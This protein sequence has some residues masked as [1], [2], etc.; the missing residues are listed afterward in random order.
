MYQ[1]I[2]LRFLLSIV[3]NTGG[4]PTR[5]PCIEV[6]LDW[7][8]SWK[9]WRVDWCC[10]IH[11][12]LQQKLGKLHSLMQPGNFTDYQLLFKTL[13]NTSSMHTSIEYIT[14]W[15]INVASFHTNI[16]LHFLGKF[17][18]AIELVIGAIRNIL[19]LL[20]CLIFPRIKKNIVD[21]V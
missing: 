20:F 16:P 12:N 8:R 6:G 11:T 4:F 9:L 7:T 3:K 15:C 13:Q 14:W 21:D 17:I 1:F 5:Y 18:Y 19:V 2:P 10:F